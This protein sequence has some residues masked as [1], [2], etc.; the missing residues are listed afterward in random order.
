M[1]ASLACCAFALCCP[2]SLASLPEI[3][4]RG[5]SS[6]PGVVGFVLLAASVLVTGYFVLVE[7]AGALA[8][9]R[10]P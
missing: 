10:A 2:A 5:G 4:L 8:S 7:V 9:V 3:T 6:W 1:N